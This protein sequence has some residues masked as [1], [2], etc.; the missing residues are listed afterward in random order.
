MADVRHS[1]VVTNGISMHVAESGPDDGPAVLLCHGFPESWYS[2]RHQLQALGDAGY[3][4]LAPDMRGYGDTDAPVD[5]RTYT[6]LHHLGDVVGLLDA[7]DI[8]QAVIVGHDW[9]APVAWTAAG[10]RPDRFR[11][12]ACLSVPRTERPLAPMVATMR[13]AFA[14]TWFYFVYFQEPGVAEAELDPAAESM[15]RGFLYT[16]SGDAPGDALRGLLGG[17]GAGL[18]DRL[19][20]PD[21]LPAWLSDDDLAY[22]V[23]EFRRTG[24]RG[25]LS[26]YRCA[27]LSWEL[28]SGL[29]G[30]ERIDQP[31]LFV[32]GERDGVLG[33]M[34]GAVEQLPSVVPGLR[35]SILLPGC[36]HWTQQE[37]PAEVNEAMLE[38]LDAL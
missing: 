4:V 37:R 30:L 28:T 33:M 12:V 34:P 6:L 3:H 9:G 7:T 16:L 19:L 11:A 14:D 35:R 24:F 29:A 2:W 17:D 20:Q 26:W 31:A 10:L 38:F 8:D 23:G 32:A 36:G 27:D 13:A 18:L 21:H 1:Q 15:L 22:Y 5:G 25:G